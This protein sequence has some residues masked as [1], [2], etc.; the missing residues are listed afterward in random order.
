MRGAFLTFPLQEGRDFVVQRLVDARYRRLCKG[1]GSLENAG[2]AP[3]HCDAGDSA[4]F[5]YRLAVNLMN[6]ARES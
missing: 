1:R 6:I 5:C 4:P 3:A 2:E